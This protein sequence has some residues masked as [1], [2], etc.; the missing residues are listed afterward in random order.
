VLPP[1][2]CRLRPDQHAFESGKLSAR[3]SSS[4][5]SRTTSATPGG[6]EQRELPEHVARWFAR[7]RDADTGETYWEP[8]I[9]EDE[10]L[11]YWEERTRVGTKKLEGV[12]EEWKGVEPICE[13]LF[14]SL[15]LRGVEL[16]FSFFAGG[17]VGPFM[18]RSVY[19]QFFEP[20]LMG[21][22]ECSA[23]DATTT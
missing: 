2:D 17:L 13:L 3:T 15:S 23:N 12:K 1:T 9:A 18:F 10:A 14:L 22:E 4:R 20:N 5:T 11:E 7:K 19:I 21:V 8:A 6:S 16:M